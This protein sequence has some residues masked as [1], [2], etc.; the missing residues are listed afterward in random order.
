M[1]NSQHFIKFSLKFLE[2]VL[3]ILIRF[4]TSIVKFYKNI[5][6]ILE[7]VDP[8]GSCLLKYNSCTPQPY[9]CT[10]QSY[11]I[12][13]TLLSRGNIH[14]EV[15]RILHPTRFPSVCYTIAVF[16]L[17]LLTTFFHSNFSYFLGNPSRNRLGLPLRRHVFN[18]HPLLFYRKLSFV[19]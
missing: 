18:I 1:S 10:A 17:D 8:K 6:L 16:T 3:I 14:R 11:A 4:P 15:R 9:N 2:N 19:F 12:V 13:P 7:E 5:L